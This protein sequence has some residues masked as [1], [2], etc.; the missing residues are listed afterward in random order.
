MRAT[1]HATG[2]GFDAHSKEL[3][4]YLNVYFHF[5]ALL[6]RQNAALNPNNTQCLQNS[7]ESRKRNVLTLV[8]SAYSTY[9]VRDTA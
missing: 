2:C 8:P 6:S 4:I 1:V 5:F 9:S 7:A 3:N